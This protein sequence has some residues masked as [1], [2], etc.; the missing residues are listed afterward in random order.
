MSQ[1]TYA[2]ELL[3]KAGIM[4]CKPSPSP[5]S[6]KSSVFDLD[7]PFDDFHLYRTLI[8]SLHYLTLTRPELSY[9]V[10]VVCQQMQ[11]PTQ[12]HFASVKRVL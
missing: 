2:T 6:A 5:S 10:N 12:A 7:A 4:E 8:G 11:A 9:P 3:E 1:R